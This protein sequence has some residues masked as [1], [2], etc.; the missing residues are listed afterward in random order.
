MVQLIM[1]L[2]SREILFENALGDEH[3][4]DILMDKRIWMIAPRDFY[5]FGLDRTTP[6]KKWVNYL[7]GTVKSQLRQLRKQLQDRFD[8]RLLVD[9]GYG[10]LWKKLYILFH[11][12][13]PGEKDAIRQ[14]SNFATGHS[15][16][17]FNLFAIHPL[18]LDEVKAD[19]CSVCLCDFE[20][21]E[22]V[23]ESVSILFSWSDS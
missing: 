8:Y 15:K 21:D 19:P 22:L 7:N 14:F 10:R 16:L 13:N 9:W 18:D 11:P 17:A 12:R 1:T 23:M 2:K 6:A 5:S 3:F 4:E 20:H